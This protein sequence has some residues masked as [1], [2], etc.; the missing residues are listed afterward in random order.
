[1]NRFVAAVAGIGLVATPG[2]AR[3]NVEIGGTAGLHMFSTN[4]GLGVEKMETATSQKNSALFGVRVGVFFQ[5]MFGVEGEFGVIPSEARSMLFSVYNIT[6]RGHVAVQL[7]AKDPANNFIPFVVAGAGILQVYQSDEADVIA[8]E[9]MVVPYAGIGAKYRAANNWGL[10]A[11]ARVLFPESSDPDSSRALDFEALLSLYR[12][13]GRPEKVEEPPPPPPP[14]KDEDPDKDGIAGAADTCPNEPED[15]DSFEDD[16][17]CPD[18]DN[19]G[20]GVGDAD[21]KCATEA[22]D[23]DNFEDDNGC[24]DPD[25][26]GDEVPDA[27]DQCGTEPE[28]KNGYQDD[29]GCPDEIPEKL[30]KFTG[31]IQGIT[32]KVN[33]ADLAGASAKALDKAVAVLAEF[34][35]IKL[36]IQGHTDDQALK[37]GG[38]FADNTELSQARAETVKAYFVSKGIDESRLTARGYGDS[39]PID[40]P[41]GLKG[42]KLNAAR[43]KNRRV[44]FKLISGESEKAEKPAEEKPAEEKKED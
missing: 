23:K 16:N 36:E 19:D 34:K 35:D 29:D 12:E 30:K 38:K 9:K 25:N 15:K 14:G 44:E 11:D 8:E 1:M 39:A 37:K 27:A 24:P 7:R 17:G 43:A 22:E 3:A 6:Y 33:S 2:L 31:V 28:T 13:F 4:N 32:F 21:D 40:D 10:R 26:D 41:K 18:P 5:N 20:D 42:G